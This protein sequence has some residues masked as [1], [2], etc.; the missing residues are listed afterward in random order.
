MS[1]KFLKVA[2][3]HMD[4]EYANPKKNLDLLVWLCRSAAALGAKLICAPEMC[5]TG[6]LYSSPGAI[7]PLAETVKGE[8][9]NVLKRLASECQVFLALG[10]A[11]KDHR[12]GMLYNSAFVIS[13][14]GQAVCHYRKINAESL[15]AAPGPS[16]Q[17]NV[18]LTPW[19]GLGLLI[20]SDA[21]N[22]LLPRVTA[23]KGASLILLPTNWPV[24]ESGFPSSLFRLRAMENGTWLLVANRGGQE[25]E[26]D[27]SKARS[28]L[29]DPGGQVSR[30]TSSGVDHRVRAYDL[31]LDQ[32]GLIEDQ[33][34]SAFN[35]RQPDQYH[36]VYGDLSRI[37]NITGF[38]A[39]PKAG[40][41]DVHALAPGSAHPLDFL[42]KVLDLFS[43]GSLVLMPQADYGDE[44]LRQIN[45]LAKKAQVGIFAAKNGSGPGRFVSGKQIGGPIKSNF[46]HWPIYDFGAARLM[47]V[48]LDSLWHP[49]LA[50]AAAKDGIDLILC[51]ALE[52]SKEDLLMLSLRPI[53][54]LAVAASC[55]SSALISLIPQGHGPGRGTTA[56]AGQ[57]ATYTVDTRL[58]RQK[59]FQDRVDF[60][61]LFLEPILEST[62]LRAHP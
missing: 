24:A 22:A 46:S 23:L 32:N 59:S 29:V 44:N 33:R 48:D 25:E 31:P 5:L 52:L 47:M 14:N 40:Y 45:R 13:P 17:D 62:W 39:L 1:D 51:P 6:Y 37:K 4:V 3:V 35:G 9:L 18:F 12:T 8:A 30:G 11:E 56:L 20:C 57:V 26:L 49:E 36:R 50:V 16:V 43:P 7:L 2:T 58:T 19:G 41:L 34:L 54:Q 55:P 21:Y 10:L 15:W 42:E 38:L 28:F 27:F 53:E 61:A 60:E